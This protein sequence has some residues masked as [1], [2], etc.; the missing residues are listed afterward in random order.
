MGRSGSIF[1]FRDL[2][3]AGRTFN[4]SRVIPQGERATGVMAPPHLYSRD[5]GLRETNGLISDIAGLDTTGGMHA[6]VPPV[7]DTPTVELERDSGIGEEW[8]ALTASVSKLRHE[9]LSPSTQQRQS[10]SCQAEVT[11]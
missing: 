8:K 6:L 3:L 10:A 11:L 2:C 1:S 7:L 9:V 4:S 5:T